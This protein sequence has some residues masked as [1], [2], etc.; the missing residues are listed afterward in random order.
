MVRLLKACPMG[1]SPGRVS[2]RLA[3][4]FAGMSLSTPETNISAQMGG[5]RADQRPHLSR[6]TRWKPGPAERSKHI[7]LF[8]P[9][10]ILLLT[11]RLVL[12]FLVACRMSPLIAPSSYSMELEISQDPEVFRPLTI[13]YCLLLPALYGLIIGI[14]KAS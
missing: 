14:D 10:G 13:L 1:R 9:R 5:S 7:I 11:S 8:D 3:P 12:L 2:G 6:S 4:A